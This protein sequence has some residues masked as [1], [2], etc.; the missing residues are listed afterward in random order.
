MHYIDWNNANNNDFYVAEEISVLCYN[1]VERK[2]PDV[3]LYINGI[4]LGL[5]ELKRSCV[6]IGEGIR[7]NLTN[8]KKE[9][10]QNFFSTIQL[11][12]AGS[13]A[14]GLKYGTTE[15]AEKYFLQWK[16]DVKATDSLS[17]LVRSIQIK[18]KNRLRDGV[19]SLC[20]K[21]RFLSLIHDFIIFDAGTKKVC[22]HNQ[23]FAN[24]AARARIANEDGGIIWNT[25]GSGKSL[26]MVWLAK[27][28]IE[29]VA[30][31]RVV[32]I[33]D[34]D[35]LDDQI[36]SLFIDVEVKV[37]RTKSCSDL[38][39]VLNKNED[40]IIC[41]LIHKYG[42]NAGKQ[43]D[44]EQY[45]KELIKD[46]PADFKAK[47]NI[48]AFIDECHRT[49]SGKLHEA[50][51]I[52][53]PDALLIG[54]TGTPLLKDDKTTSLEAFGTYI[55]TYKFDEGVEDGVVLDLRYE[56]RDVDQDLSSQDKVDLWFD[57]KTLGL[58]DRAKTQLKQTVKMMKIPVEEIFYTRLLRL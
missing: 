55:H 24:I 3:V 46:L 31:S 11:I 33:T 48:I 5:F 10:I 4:A 21:E 50:V 14:E 20:H 26:I 13:E 12:F 30:D 42:H 8:Q 9:Y 44:V 45:R 2:R 43:A 16:E 56:A 25:Q 29:N 38:R 6:S 17:L 18:A 27:W 7:Q 22:R 35:E 47:G 58:T 23:F 52:L 54:F 51:K 34:R 36:E 19:V 57:T 41:S 40:A 39:E 37:K 15:T 32:I 28:I 49:N 1:H 53:M